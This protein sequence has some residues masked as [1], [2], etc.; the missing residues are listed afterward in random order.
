MRIKEIIFSKLKRLYLGN[1][2]SDITEIGK[3]LKDQH[4][5]IADVFYNELL[6]I[7]EISIILENTNID[8]NLHNTIADW[9][10][11]LF[12][13]H[14]EADLDSLIERQKKIGTVHATTNVNLNYF[15]HGIGILKD[16]IYFQMQGVTGFG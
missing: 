2:K 13:D 3:I 11:S 9:I 4:H 8:K 16:E 15:N 10:E 5:D 14:S 7:P 6:K 12:A 1:S